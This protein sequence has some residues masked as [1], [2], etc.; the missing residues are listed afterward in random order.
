MNRSYY[1]CS[2][3][4]DSEHIVCLIEEGEAFV[5]YYNGKE[6]CIRF[7]F[8][9]PSPENAKAFFEALCNVERVTFE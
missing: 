1:S 4:G 8:D 6:V 5:S 7:Y 9:P 3:L 2:I